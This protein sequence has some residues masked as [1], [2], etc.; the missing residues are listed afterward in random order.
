MKVLVIH[1]HLH[2]LGG[3]EVLTKILVYGLEEQGY[4][5]V[6]LSK[7]FR[8]D[9]FKPTPN[10]TLER[11]RIINEEDSI[12]ARLSN[13]IHTLDE[14]FRKHGKLLP[15][16]MIQEPIYATLVKAVKPGAKVGMYVHFPKEEELTP[17]NLRRFLN[18]YRFPNMYE[19]FYRVADLHI[20]N[21]NY[22]AR[23][24]YKLY[25][26]PSNVVY[27]AIPK[28]YY[29]AGEEVD[30]KGKGPRIISVARFVPQ[31][32]LD[33]LIQWFKER[34]KPEVP[35]ASLL[36]VG[37]P[38][39]RYMD[40]YEKLKELASS[41]EGVELIDRP[42]KPAELAKY[43]QASKVY[44][45]LR[46]GEHFGM[47]PVEAMTQ[48]TIPVVPRKTGLAELIVNGYNGYAYESDEEAIKTLI[49]LLKMS[50]DEYLRIAKNA[51]RTSWH[52]TPTI[53]TSGVINYLKLLT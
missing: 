20:T 53:F 19:C 1:P 4:E 50:G 9:L 30:I 48:A 2:F 33:V 13:I 18:N 26:I 22:T 3:S 10:V 5:V 51:W 37:I 40:H 49:K 8:E 36:I 43:Y 17:E 16:I 23:A 32:R 41:T 46:I 47:A 38:D 34:I 29:E 28:E 24:L 25:G 35:D 12:K 42:M 11:F 14:V 6:V 44:V 45:H 27:P 52:F 7:D 31:K 39:S 15:F 21:S